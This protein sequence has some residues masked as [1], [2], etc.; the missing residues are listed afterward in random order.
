MTIAY[1]FGQASER[2]ISTTG[3]ISYHP[4][5]R[6][7]VAFLLIH[8]HG[9]GVADKM[10]DLAQTLGLAPGDLEEPMRDIPPET[11]HLTVT[12]T[13]LTLHSHGTILFDRPVDHDWATAAQSTGYVIVT[14]GVDGFTGRMSD[15]DRY[16]RRRARIHTAKIPAGESV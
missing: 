15:L 3:W 5:T 8:P 7:D 9:G 2:L 16:L 1:L 12:D 11:A 4:T 6:E 10:R 14:V 13:T